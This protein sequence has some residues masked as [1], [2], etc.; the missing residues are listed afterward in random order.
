L[1]SPDLLPFLFNFGWIVFAIHCRSDLAVQ[2]VF[3]VF[4]ATALISIKY[5][6]KLYVLPN[7]SRF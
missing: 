3:S 7:N 1:P 6:K 2:P 4:L 5:T